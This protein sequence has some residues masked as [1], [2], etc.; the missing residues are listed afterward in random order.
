MHKFSVFYKIQLRYQKLS[1]PLKLGTIQDDIIDLRAYIYSS[2]DSS[3]NACQGYLYELEASIGKLIKGLIQ[4][5][6]QS[7][8]VLKVVNRF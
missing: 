2:F 7:D 1:H 3:G 4:Q 6:L 5:K 8:A